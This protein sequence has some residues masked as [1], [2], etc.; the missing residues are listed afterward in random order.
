[1]I[2]LK[3]VD[4]V[5]VRQYMKPN[6]EKKIVK[7]ADTFECRQDSPAANHEKGPGDQK[8]PEVGHTNG[9][10]RDQSAAAGKPAALRSLWFDD[11]TKE[12]GASPCCQV[13]WY[14]WIYRRTK[15]GH[16]RERTAGRDSLS[17]LHSSEARPL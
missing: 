13:S 15:T 1:M 10:K 3:R 17:K 12:I 4:F 16:R 5:T 11:Q 2:Q 14:G 8:F 6:H 9:R 7:K